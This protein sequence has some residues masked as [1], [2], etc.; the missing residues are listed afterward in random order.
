MVKPTSPSLICDVLDHVQRHQVLVQL[1]F[2]NRAQGSQN[3][4]S[5]TRRSF[6]QHLVCILSFR[7]GNV[8]RAVR[9]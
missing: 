8:M 1:R 6:A 5:V 9:S 4:F 3:I 2:L 7:R